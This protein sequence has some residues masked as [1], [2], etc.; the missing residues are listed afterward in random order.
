LLQ[1]QV[2]S[3]AVT[4]CGAIQ[5]PVVK[6][7]RFSVGGQH[8][9]DLNCRRTPSL[10]GGKGRHR[11]FRADEAVAPVSAHMDSSGLAGK[12]TEGHRR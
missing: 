5:R 2:G 9:I 8:D 4:I 12:K 11:I 7:N 1:I 6:Y 10:G 3:E